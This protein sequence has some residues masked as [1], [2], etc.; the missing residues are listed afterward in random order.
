MRSYGWRWRDSA[1]TVAFLRLEL[2]TGIETAAVTGLHRRIAGVH[3]WPELMA[4]AF[5]DAF[6]PACSSAFRRH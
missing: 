4:A 5:P 3:Q 2:L 1:A 6:D